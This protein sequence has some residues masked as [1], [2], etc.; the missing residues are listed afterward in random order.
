MSSQTLRP[1]VP[2]DVP[3]ILKLISEVYAEYD[4]V[5]YAET[6]EQHLLE[7]G[8]YFRKH[9]GEFWVVEEDGLVRATVAVL[10][11]EDSG[12]L[13]SLYVHPSLRRQGWGR[14]LT[15]LAMD[16]A[17]AA[18][19]RKMILWS[20]TRFTD[21]HRLY[22]NLGFTEMGIRDL[23]DSNNSIEYGFERSL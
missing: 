6:E 12:E 2:E 17:R 9:G 13:K 22:R 7:P 19:K 23:K 4:C 20:D 3:G 11:H 16:Y 5:L 18:G 1:T 21:A 15:V 10:L 14:R 8:S